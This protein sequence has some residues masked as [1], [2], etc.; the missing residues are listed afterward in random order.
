[1]AVT[2]ITKENISGVSAT[3]LTGSLPAIDGQYIT[4]VPSGEIMVKSAANP[5]NTS[6]H[7]AGTM[8]VNTT[9]GEIFVCT[10]AS[11]D[12]NT[13]TNVGPGTTEVATVVW[14]YQGT[15]YG[16]VVGGYHGSPGRNDEIERYSFTSN[17]VNNN[18]GSLIAL[19]TVPSGH[20]STDYGWVTGGW[21]GADITTIEKFSWASSA[22]SAATGATVGGNMS[23]ATAASTQTGTTAYLTGGFDNP[24]VTTHHTTRKFSFDSTTDAVIVGTMA[25]S[26]GIY[27]NIG[28]SSDTHGYSAGGYPYGRSP[29]TVSHIEKFAFATDTQ[30]AVGC[31]DLASPASYV[32]G[33]NSTTYG[34][35]DGGWNS[36]I[37]TA[38][39]EAYS[40]AS[41]GTASTIGV[42][43]HARNWTGGSSSTTHGYCHGGRNTSGTYMTDVH[44]YSYASHGNANN[45]MNVATARGGVPSN[46]QF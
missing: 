18:I 8:W 26:G 44:Q 2:K 1:M 38:N 23:L 45:I 7:S 11:T 10:D 17:N 3:K 46:I 6:N 34:Y 33:S 14:A 31:G 39:M 13:W 37:Y 30:Q 32:S 41:E 43:T 42:L 27:H 20:S 35:R 29:N 40:F 36:G 12:E 5:T 21:N 25:F 19:N 16:Y 28:W 9:N 4:N 22:S 24:N 15:Q